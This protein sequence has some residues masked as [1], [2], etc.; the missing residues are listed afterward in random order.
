MQWNVSSA[1]TTPWL[2]R[3]ARIVRSLALVLFA[4]LASSAAP[5]C[6]AQ[7]SD[8]AARVTL[9]TLGLTALAGAVD[10]GPISSSQL[11]TLTLTLAP[12]P[13]RTTA[14]Q[15]FLTDLQTP[16]SPN[17]RKWITP[18]EFA[19][20][21]GATPE[22]L[23][24]ATAWAQAGGLTVAGVSPSGTRMT[25]TGYASQVE[26]LLA[27]SLD[28][29]QIG[30]NPYFANVTQP[31][32]PAP[33][34]ALFTSIEG[35]DNLPTAAKPGTFVNGVTTALTLAALGPF[36]DHN[37]S[38]ILVIDAS[39]ATGSPSSS[40]IAAYEL[41]FRQAAAQG[42]TTLL[43]RAASL[44]GF[45][46]GLPEITAIANP[47]DGADT[48]TPTFI[49][50]AWQSAPGLPADQLRH[51]PDLT[52]ASVSELA[53]TL[54]SIAAS[55]P[56]GRAGNV[57]PILYELGT[58][59]GLY[60]QP[61]AKAG[62][63]EAETGL[64]LIDPEKLARAFPRGTASSFVSLS[65][66]SY[67]VTY[68]TPVTFTSNVTSGA[69]GAAPSGTVSFALG[70]GTTVTAPVVS[71]VATYTTTATQLDAGTISVQASYSGDGTYV[72]A[73]SP[74]A[75]FYIAPEASVL[76]ATV[77]MG[78][79]LGGT[80]SVSVTDAS[81]NGA[82]QPSG[83]V[84]LLVQ[85]TQTSLAQAL[86]AGTGG[87]ASTTFQV[88]ASVVGTL[89][90]SINCT[91]TTDFTC[92]NPYT[93]RVTVAKATPGI[94]IS[95]TPTAPVAGQTITLNATLTG[96][97]TGPTP[98]GSVTFYDGTTVLNSANL[99]ANG[100]VAETGTVPN[101]ST[102]SIMATYNGDPN[103]TPVSASESS[104]TST[105]T[106]SATISAT[107]ATAG[108][109]VEIPVTVMLPSGTPTG[110]VLASI[111]TSAGPSASGTLVANAGTS[112]A[113]TTISL[114]VPAAGT[115]QVAVG[116]AAT[117]SFTCNTVA[118]TLTS[119][120]STSLIA[121]T[122]TLSL[123]PAVPLAGQPVMLTAT[124]TPATAGAVA[125]SGTV[126]FYNGT[127]QIGS[128]AIAAG[129]A[130]ATLT[131]TTSASLTAVYSGDSNYLPSA[132]T[133]IAA[134]TTLEPV[135][136]SLATSG[137]S[138]LA[139]TNVS[140]TAQVSGTASAGAAPAGTVSF[141]V[142]G[143]VP[144][145]LGT[146]TLTAGTGGAASVAQLNTQ[147]IPSG[148]QS[149]YAIYS[150]DAS[151]A[152]GVSASVAVGY[153]DYAVVFTP[154]TMTLRPGETG[155]VTLAVNA[156]TGFAGTIS[157]ACTTPANTLITCSV[158]Q[159]SLAGAGT[160]VLTINTVAG[161]TAE[162]HRPDLRS[163]GGVGLAALLF[164]LLPRRRRGRLPGLLLMLALA[165]F[166][167]LSGCG[168]GTPGTPV[169][170]GTP[171]GTVNLTINTS[172]SYGA[173]GIA[174]DYSYPLTIAQ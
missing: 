109:T 55:L 17:Y 37:D 13:S 96:A 11:L 101:A 33:I 77:S 31:S 135:S 4:L 49:R 164:W 10:A 121:T 89:T 42:S 141:Y 70:N 154:A 112:T 118:F 88:P 45:P 58:S 43:T 59:P 117:D 113:G 171:L 170:G 6:A 46:S 19:K 65:L 35:L 124:V 25:L 92:S 53:A 106:L 75:Q 9:E 86:T 132:S 136:V 82:G 40:E 26:A 165:T 24:A 161:V 99:A 71:G 78:A 157:I 108:T 67:S 61:D 95:Y 27:V 144:A 44:Q 114:T 60:T 47:G 107:T 52:A 122:T 142:A 103:Y 56:G 21:Y 169:G 174:H 79:T 133:P 172:A 15:H 80:Y 91:T 69:G 110:T 1:R 3:L 166:V 74:S 137:A 149:L 145:L 167:Q 119:M 12:P 125:V 162:N 23:A 51:D 87:T 128:G 151:F 94:S 14:L 76:S 123:L 81:A 131:S 105:A 5:V 134:S 173:T 48:Q 72:S 62:T 84:T 138:G 160:S 140:L 57:N 130:T 7:A 90:L 159:C 168:S 100:T 30:G 104:S 64:G 83:N 120:A 158:S 39:N 152:S 111:L 116:C 139:G 22:Q 102:H 18:A 29:L 146:A 50:P 163:L 85:G 36:I 115:Y 32:L 153:S 16:G 28:V 8:A 155:S 73:Q 147:G 63:W 127:T 41:L 38:P 93:T 54:T 126:L 97:G 66:S 2:L 156:T 148:S 150:G 129:Q 34:F 143:T 20:S 98:T 68:G